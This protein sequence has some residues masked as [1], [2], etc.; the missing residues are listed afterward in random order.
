MHRVPGRVNLNTTP[1]FVQLNDPND[2][3]N[4]DR[5]ENPITPEVYNGTT[6]VIRYSATPAFGT[7]TGNGAVYQSLAWGYSTAFELDRGEFGLAGGTTIPSISG[8]GTAY[9]STQDTPFGYNFKGFIE[10]RTG[11]SQNAPTNPGFPATPAYLAPFEDLR[12]RFVFHNYPSRFAGL[13]GPSS[14]ARLPIQKYLPLDVGGGP[15]AVRRTYDVTLM[16]PHPDLE[17][18]QFATQ[19]A[20]DEYDINTDLV[21]AGSVLRSQILSTPLFERSQAEL[22]R[23]LR[24]QDRNPMFRMRNTAKLANMTTHHSNVFL[25]RLTIGYFQVD[26]QSGEVGAE[27][28]IDTNNNERQHGMFIVDRTIPVAFERGQAHNA[29]NSVLLQ[30]LDQ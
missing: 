9:A 23:D 5:G 8:P 29:L 12:N 13:F 30:S 6:N 21:G 7:F 25:V 22:H 2:F 10:S 20:I 24:L 15:A 19:P 11:Y 16:R 18:R 17:R 4:F 27:Y 1:D 28:G 26:P 3:T 14:A